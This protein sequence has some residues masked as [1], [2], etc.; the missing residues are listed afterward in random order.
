LKTESRWVE[1]K[2]ARQTKKTTP[3]ARNESRDYVSQ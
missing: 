2:D 3:R 1:V